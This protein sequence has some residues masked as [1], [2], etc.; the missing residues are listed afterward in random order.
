MYHYFVRLGVIQHTVEANQMDSLE[1]AI[2]SAGA[3]LIERLAVM[4]RISQRNDWIER[5][6]FSPASEEAA[7]KLKSWMNAAG[8]NTIYDP[9]TNVYG[10]IVFSEAGSQAPRIHLGSHYDTVVNAGAFDGILGVLIG[11]AVV[12]AIVES[13]EPFN[14][15]LSVLAFSDEEGVRFNTTFL[16]SAY[17]SGQFDEAWL[18]KED[19]YGKTLGEWLVDR[20]ESIDTIL[21]AHRTPYIRP[22]DFFLEAHIEQ[23]PILEDSNRALGVFTR[24]AAQL[25][26][27]VILKGCAG[28]AGTIPAS[29]R[30]DPL[31]VASEMILAVNALCRSDERIRAT[32]GQLEILPNA[33][34][35]IPGQVRFS[36]DMRH[37]DKEGL[38]KAHNKLT[39]D[40]QTIAKRSELEFQY[41]LVHQAQDAQLDEKLTDALSESCEVLQGASIRMFSGAGHDS[42]KIAQVCPVSMLAVRCKDGLSHHPQEFA[43]N[44]DCLLA[45]K[46]MLRTVLAIDKN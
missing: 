7:Y 26:S 35:V 28:H 12:E 34:N 18:H 19:E 42:M 13:N 3:R 2:E 41:K 43:S 36:I 16:G 32:V 29:L 1:S 15:N 40:I 33:S 45:F 14:H 23:G 17:L 30:K 27:E 25:R 11:I 4:R 22:Q 46:A 38:N 20:A 44:A 10:Q 24:I 21:G 5:I 31:P 37:P 39:Q 6:L 8:M 9:L